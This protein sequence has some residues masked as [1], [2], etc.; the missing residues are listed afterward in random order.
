MFNIFF[1]RA[2]RKPTV[3]A[4]SVKDTNAGKKVEIKSQS[5]G[6][7]FKPKGTEWADKSPMGKNKIMNFRGSNLQYEGLGAF[8]PQNRI[9]SMRARMVNEIKC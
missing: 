3:I 1:M 5:T 6:R 4:T 8:Q 7:S 2:E 9:H